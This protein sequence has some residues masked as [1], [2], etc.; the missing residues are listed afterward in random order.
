ENK[1]RTSRKTLWRRLRSPL[2]PTIFHTAAAA[3]AFVRP[4]AGDKPHLRA[5]EAATARQPCDRPILCS[6]LPR[7]RIAIVRSRALSP[8]PRVKQKINLAAAETTPPR[9]KS[10]SAHST[11]STSPTYA[12]LAICPSRCSSSTRHQEVTVFC[13]QSP[14][15]TL[16][17]A[18]V[19]KPILA[20]IRLRV[21]AGAARPG[22]P[23]GPALAFYRI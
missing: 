22:P 17:D 6:R 14:M 12:S 5:R 19:R 8:W 23:V 11:R 18:A 20:T 7:V 1:H 13:V 4:F 21:P 16:K 3:Q 2:P 15:S 10:V 9:N